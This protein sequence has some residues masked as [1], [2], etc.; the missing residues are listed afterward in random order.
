MTSGDT[1]KINGLWYVTPYS[2]M[3]SGDAIQ[4]NDFWWHYVV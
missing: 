2:F 1:I 4:F 3:R